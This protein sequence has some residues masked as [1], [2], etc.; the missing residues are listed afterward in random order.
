MDKGFSKLIMEYP[1]SGIRRMFDLAAGY[2]GFINL[3]NGE[4]DFVTPAHIRQAA[5]EGLDLGL[6]K[7]A[8]EPG[9]PAFRQAAAD[10]CAAQYGYA[11]RPEQILATGGGVEAVM[12]TL[13]SL[14][15]PG[16]EVIIPDPSYTCYPGQAQ[17]LGARV[18]RLPLREEDGFCP[19]PE[20]LEA[21]I[22]PRTKVLILNYPNNPT[23]AV[24]T[25]EAVQALVP[26]IK[27]HGIWVLSDEVYE[28]IVFDGY[29]HVS[30]AQFDELADRA[31]VANSLSKTYAMTG[32]RLGYLFSR[33]EDLMRRIPKMHQPLT[34]CIPGFIQHAG[35]AAI[36]GSQDCVDEMVAH[37]TRRRALM[38]QRL[39]EM[40]GMRPVKHTGTFCFYINIARTGIDSEQAAERLLREAGVLTT[41]GTVFGSGGKDYLRL[42][43]ANSEDKIAEGME[44]M[45]RF[46]AQL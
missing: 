2:P 36:A 21:L 34:A 9:L 35:A 7:Y 16:D 14:V 40:K 43:F 11:V 5:K 4:P 1:V 17:L 25:R 38:Q 29:T 44:R 37:Y 18:V 45:H 26:V 23:G 13:M 32:W 46:F 12:L 15:N 10:K 20:S 30:L 27:R 22:T 24:L 19:T 28:K 31:V 8:P 39:S 6:T 42:S 3:C 41:P 33:N